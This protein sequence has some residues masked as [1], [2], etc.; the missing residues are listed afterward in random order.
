MIADAYERAGLEAEKGS[1]NWPHRPLRVDI[2]AARC[3][4][5]HHAVDLYYRT[6]FPRKPG[7]KGK[8]RR[9]A[10]QLPLE[11][12]H[13]VLTLSKK[14]LNPAQI[15]SKLGQSDPKAKGRI[16]KQIVIAEKRYAEIVANIRALGAKQ[17]AR[18][19]S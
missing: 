15:A 1:T 7:I 17:E 10:P 16:V 12:L 18:S 11:Y 5:H 6:Y 8:P 2:V 4:I 9:G 14:G 3:K 13:Q 19:R